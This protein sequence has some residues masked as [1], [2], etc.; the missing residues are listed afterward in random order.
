MIKANNLWEQ[1]R[2]RDCTTVEQV[3]A[4]IDRCYNGVDAAP[5]ESKRR[6]WRKKLLWLGR[7]RRRMAVCR[8][9]N[10]QDH[11]PPC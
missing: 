2:V 4:E 8:H 3:N 9:P 6:E 7:L 1:K 5:S 10:T 11:L